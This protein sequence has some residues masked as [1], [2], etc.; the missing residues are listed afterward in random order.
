M[1]R[2]IF[3]KNVQIKKNKKLSKNFVTSEYL[4]RKF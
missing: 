1:N 3:L 4:K 2:L